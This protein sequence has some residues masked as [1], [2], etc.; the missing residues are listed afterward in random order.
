MSGIAGRP[1]AQ[2]A[3][4][5]GLLAVGLYAAT[6]QLVL[7]WVVLGDSMLP[8]LSDGDRV[9]VDLWTYRH[10]APRP[11][12]IVLFGGPAPGGSALVKRV[13]ALPAGVSPA[14]RLGLWPPPEAGD[15]SG[16]LWIRGDNAT[17]SVD[18]RHF[19]AVPPGRV[20]GRVVFRYWPL[21]RAGPIR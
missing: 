13:V 10:R 16:G 11:G 18:S 2:V 15:P 20:R 14:P 3:L 21:S 17:R 4:L 5:L 1:V 19:G 6:D 7:P 9:V 8:A 12:E